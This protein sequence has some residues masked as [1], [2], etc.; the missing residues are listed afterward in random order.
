MQLQLDY[1]QL[2]LHFLLQSFYLLVWVFEEVP[3]KLSKVREASVSFIK[4]HEWLQ[5]I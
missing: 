5:V 2:V 1:L 4:V 3:L